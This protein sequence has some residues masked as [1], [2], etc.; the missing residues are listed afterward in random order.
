M[1][2][3][4]ASVK[5]PVSWA[6]AR[7]VGL[8]AFEAWIRT[9]IRPGFRI[10][11]QNLAGII[12]SMRNL[13]QSTCLEPKMTILSDV[14]WWSSE[15]PA[16][17][18]SRSKFQPGCFRRMKLDRNSLRIQ[19]QFPEVSGDEW[20]YAIFRKHCSGLLTGHQ[21]SI[22]HVRHSNPDAFQKVSLGLQV[23][24]ARCFAPLILV[25]ARST[26]KL[27]KCQKVKG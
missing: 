18:S 17:W 24:A 7:N 19:D 11:S 22:T 16:F 5:K 15:E 27:Q 6:R 4:D 20:F 21:Y 10:S 12:G 9:E 3:H 1:I 25:Q 23:S 14:A 26:S 13:D 2:W 8:D